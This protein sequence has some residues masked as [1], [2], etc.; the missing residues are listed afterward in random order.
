MMCKH[1]NQ[2]IR[3]GKKARENIHPARMFILDRIDTPTNQL[4]PTVFLFAAKP[5]YRNESNRPQ[6]GGVESALEVARSSNFGIQSF[7]VDK[8]C[9]RKVRVE[10]SADRPFN[11]HG[12]PTLSMNMEAPGK[13]RHGV[14]AAFHR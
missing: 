10:K 1:F 6:M 9:G 5:I 11:K 3:S 14:L 12:M 8:L 13:T 7:Q 4:H 2:F